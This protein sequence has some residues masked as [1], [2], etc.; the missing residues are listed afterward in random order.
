MFTNRLYLKSEIKVK[1]IFNKV[2]I[3][4]QNDYSISIG[5]T[6]MLIKI[7]DNLRKLAD[8]LPCDLYAVGGCVRNSLLGLEQDDFDLCGVL[9]PEKISSILEGTPFQVKIKSKNLGYCNILIDDELFEYV[10]FRRESYAEGGSHMP[11]K[12][13]FIDDIKED[14]K[15]RDLTCNAIYYDIKND[16]L[17]DFYGGLNDIKH[18]LLRTVENPEYV[19][20]K[21]GVRILR[22]FRFSAELGFKIEKETFNAAIR[23]AQNLRD[24]T[25]E[26]VLTELKLILNSQKR[27]AG[28]TKSKFMNVLKIFNKYSIWQ[29]LGVDVTKIKFNMVKKVDDKACGFLI[30]IVDTVEPI[31]ISYYLNLVLANMGVSRKTSNNV[32]NI[33]SG[34]YD[35]LNN[36][37]NKNYFFKYFDN[38]PSIYLLLIHKSKYLA[39]KYQFFYKYLIK[40]KLVISLKDLKINGDDIAKAYPKVNPK[41]FKPILDSLLSDV[42]DCKIE[43]N[44]E[45]L[46]KAVDQK[47]KYL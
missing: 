38:F 24:L 21:D 12:V 1:S 37:D 46:I 34:Y 44:K 6:I 5:G 42:F 33:L 3:I 25:G 29:Y 23:Y 36:L 10:T 7:S 15:R 30:D 45:E 4:C 40:H 47:L 27:Y 20:S 32:I 8:I 9:K 16:K 11:D 35:A 26:R 43:N 22:L 13:E 31:S 19:L 39:M 17:I 18:K 28:Q 2:D 41:R 14:A